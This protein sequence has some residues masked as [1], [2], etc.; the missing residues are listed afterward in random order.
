MKQINS[1]RSE[2]ASQVR[3]PGTKNFLEKRATRPNYLSSPV[4]HA[5]ID[6]YRK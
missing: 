4:A 1:Q 2:H 5:T 6:I 3:G